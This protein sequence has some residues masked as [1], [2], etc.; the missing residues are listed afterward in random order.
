MDPRQKA[1]AGL[2][3]LLLLL[4]PL[5][6]AEAWN[7]EGGTVAQD[8]YSG[9]WLNAIA[10]SWSVPFSSTTLP[11]VVGSRIYVG[12]MSGVACFSVQDGRLVW[13]YR[14][15]Y[16]VRTILYLDGLYVGT[17]RE[18]YKL[19][20]S[21]ELEWRRTEYSDMNVYSGGN[22]RVITGSCMIDYGG[23]VVKRFNGTVY[24]AASSGTRHYVVLN[25]TTLAAFDQSGEQ[26]WVKTFPDPV[27]FVSCSNDKVFATLSGQTVC[28]DFRGNVLWQRS[29]RLL[30]HGDFYHDHVVL[31]SDGS[32]FKVLDSDGTEMY[33]M[34]ETVSS[35]ALTPNYMYL[36]NEFGRLTVLSSGFTLYD[37]FQTTGSHIALEGGYLVMSSSAEI[38][39]YRYGT[40]DLTVKVYE[41]ASPLA[42]ATV[43]VTDDKGVSVVEQTGSDGVARFQLKTHNVF[44]VEARKSGYYSSTTYV[45]GQPGSSVEISLYLGKV[46]PV[47]PY[48]ATGG[49]DLL[50]IVA[51]ALFVAAIFLII[52]KRGS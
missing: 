29:G 20:P 42:G 5:A 52:W 36:V 9:S 46:V 14:T 11:L 27:T 23:N 34:N 35:A 12:N 31:I 21:K 26:V 39:A 43:L 17:M 7:S 24:A 10:F 44:K 15:K 22:G 41:G 48:S 38:S 50:Q 37:S 25:M 16:P 3:L 19:S 49:V 51:V 18:L 4:S 47:Q 45:V 32:V 40:F 13:F 6:R 30:A 8:F 2:A 1:W 33:R 28:M